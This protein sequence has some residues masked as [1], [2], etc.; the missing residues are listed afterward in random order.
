VTTYYVDSSAIVKRYVTETGS[1]WVQDLCD[2]AAGH[3]IALAHVG[4]VEIAAAQAEG[5]ITDDPNMHA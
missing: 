1:S 2:P 5:L 4:L 3:V